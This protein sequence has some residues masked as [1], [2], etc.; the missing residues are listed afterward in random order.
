MTVLFN[1]VRPLYRCENLTAVW[2]AY[3]GNKTFIQGGYIDLTKYKDNNNYDVVVTDEFVRNKA[4]HQKIIMIAHGLTGG[5]LYGIDQPSGQFK[6]NPDSC[7]LVD[8][9]IT[10]SEYGRKFAA[11][12]AGI[13]I[14][15]CL[16]L[17][18]P[19]TD[20]YINTRKGDGNTILSHYRRAYLYLPTFRAKYDKPAPF[21]N[22]EYLNF[23][24]KEDE[25]FVIKPHMF[26]KNKILSKSFTNIYEISSS[27]PT[28]P[29][30]LD[31]DVVITD[32]SSAMFDAY[33]LNKPVVLTAD[34][35]DSYL[36]T[37]GMYMKYPYE[38]SS[39]ALSIKS[40]EEK[41][42]A[43][44]RNAYTYGMTDIEYKCRE[45]TS[46]AC[47]GQSSKRVVELIKSL[48]NNS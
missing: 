42:I 9:Y 7:K 32:F 19:R 38:Y 30:L 35:N 41:L 27:K 21:I 46:G 4:P 31:C 43:F 36:T 12:A 34:E 24:L 22:Y 25:L 48:E 33:F 40:N 6:F 29:Y 2:N 5:K 11:S 3:N 28:I 13:P 15:K 23:L 20:A 47:D 8:Y 44:L 14:E 26:N 1:S 17:G 16:P 45:R 18:M 39:R 37:R 10:S